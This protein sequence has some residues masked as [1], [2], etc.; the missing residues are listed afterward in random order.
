MRRENKHMGTVLTLLQTGEICKAIQNSYD[1][2]IS[3]ALFKYQRHKTVHETIR[4][5]GM[6]ANT[7]VKMSLMGS[8]RSNSIR[9][10]NVTL[11]YK[12][13]LFLNPTSVRKVKSKRLIH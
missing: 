3:T 2:V 6:E 4:T 8:S 7:R 10:S 13:N 5:N 1:H 11:F 9:S 12:Q